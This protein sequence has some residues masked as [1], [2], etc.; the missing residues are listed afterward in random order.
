MSKTKAKKKIKK[1][2]FVRYEES[3]LDRDIKRIAEKLNEII[4]YLND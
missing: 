2:E 1:I 4:D 3:A